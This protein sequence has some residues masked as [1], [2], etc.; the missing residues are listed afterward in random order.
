MD[1][2]PVSKPEITF[3][4]EAYVNEAVRSGW[5]SSLGEFINK[6]EKNFSN[7]CNTKYALTV[8][9]G[10]VGL[11]L[12]LVALGIK[13]GDEVIIPDL[14]FIATANAVSYTG[15]IPVLADIELDSLCI[16]T[17]SI[18]K[19]IT[20]KTK[21]II[22]VH[23]Y[24]HPANMTGI[25]RLAKKYGLYVIEDAAEAHGAKIGDQKVGS[26]GDIGVF[27]LY[28]NKIITT[29]EG[30]VITTNNKKLYNKMTFLRDHAMSS[31]K[32][33]WHT[34]IGFNYRMTNLQAALGVGQLERISEILKK[35]EF[36]FEWYS[37]ELINV[38]EIRLNSTKEG[39]KNAYW[40]IYIVLPKL[41]D[42]KRNTLMSKLKE[43]NIDS[44]P[45]F[46]PMSQL[47]MYKT[48]TPDSVNYIFEKGINL[49]TFNEITREQVRYICNS[50]K[51]VL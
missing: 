13:P 42:K 44:R 35:R 15:A 40:L 19:L 16:C 47:P 31:D 20:S 37:E 18:E 24:G 27:S 4:D 29:G 48:N 51:S 7:F 17:K 21:A 5:V 26:F 2:I 12:S 38:P 41:N 14:T 28:G 34:E 1:F 43:Y 10:T 49:P 39:Y 6:F 23:L 33:Y 50:L 11:H 3:S 9:N 46:Y 8:S 22:A 25:N 36:I 32:R 30:G 45:F